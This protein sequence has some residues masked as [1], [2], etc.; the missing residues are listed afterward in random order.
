[1]SLSSKAVH[2]LTLVSVLSASIAA[3]AKPHIHISTP[4]VS[5]P[6]VNIGSVSLTPIGIVPTVALKPVEKTGN[7]AINATLATVGSGLSV[8]A[9]TVQAGTSPA[10]QVAGVIGGKESLGD[11]AKTIVTGPGV[12]IASVGEAVSETNAA[13]IDVPVVAAQSIGGDVGKTVMTIATGPTRLTVE[14]AAT[15]VIEAGGILQGQSPDMLI[16]QPFAAALRS[17][18]KQYEG[19]AQPVPADVRARLASAY[20]AEVLDAARWTVGSISISVPDIVNLERKEFAGV[21][22][23]VTVGH[24]T[25][26]VR[27]PGNDYHWWAHE[28]Q[29]QVQYH[30][31]GIDQFAFKYVTSCHEVESAAE[32]KAQQVVPVLFPM[33]LAC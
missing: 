15:G 13:V 16:A 9:K 21:D 17:A 5:I 27:D 12:V 8:A 22:N 1:V 6:H 26:F 14:F 11:A 2:S 33:N 7:A 3:S 20:P 4:H 23:A 28:L 30:E 31:W 19:Q 18:E 32:N 10:F 29:H 25:V 24:V